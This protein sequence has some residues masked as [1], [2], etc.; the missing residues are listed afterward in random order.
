MSYGW[1]TK[2]K[3]TNKPH[4]DFFFKSVYISYLISSKTIVGFL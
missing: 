4:L 1:I 2:I 3:T